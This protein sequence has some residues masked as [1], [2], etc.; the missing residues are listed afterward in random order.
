MVLIYAVLSIL[1]YSPVNHNSMDLETLRNRQA[2]LKQQYTDDPNSG[3]HMMRVSGVVQQS[4]LAIELPTHAGSIQAGL[5]PAAGGDGTMACS[6]DMLLEAL[7]GCAGVTLS[8]VSLSMGIKVNQGEI[9][10]EGDLDFK[11]TLGVD[12][13]SPIG[14]K[15]I[16]LRFDLDTDADQETEAKLISLTERYCVIYQTLATANDIQT[17]VD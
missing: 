13:E 5:H 2:P 11:G 14:F 6:G 3:I 7:I 8:A 10:A 4:D 15:Q 16:R 17:V 9:T 1:T 12:R